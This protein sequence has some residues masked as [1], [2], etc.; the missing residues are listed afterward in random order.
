[1]AL[2]AF[3]AHVLVT[4]HPSRESDLEETRVALASYGEHSA[5]RMCDVSDER[6]VAELVQS[7]LDVAGRLD[8]LVHHAGVM[9]RKP[10]LDMSRS[11]WDRVVDVNLTGTWLLNRATARPMVAQRYG[12]IVNMSSIYAEIVGPLPEAPYYASKAGVANLSRGLAA[13]WGADGVTVNCIAPGVF[14]PTQM[15]A[16]LAE[17]PQRLERM[18]ARTLLGRLGDPARDLAGA[19]VWL[20]SDAAAYVTGQLIYVDGGWTAW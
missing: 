8:I 12:R 10:T 6:Q 7:A 17:D 15:T 20:V 13:E 3:G 16:P 2:A 1:V 11:D 4:D 18:A 9:L 19:V 5:V 14:Y